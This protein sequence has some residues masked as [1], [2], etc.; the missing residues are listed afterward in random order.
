M[1]IKNFKKLNLPEFPGV[2]YFKDSKKKILYIGRA[3]S[4]NDRV[5]SYFRTDLI[6]SR[7]PFLVS[8]VLESHT[9][10]FTETDS[11]LEAIILE[12]NE[13]RKHLPYFNT[14][15]KD[16]KSYNFAIITDEEFPRVIII[17]SRILGKLN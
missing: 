6:K 13:I 1:K 8:M 7:G 14:L 5:G 2:Y 16:D 9:I 12:A 17:R 15:G 3:T 10:E 4:L 11:V